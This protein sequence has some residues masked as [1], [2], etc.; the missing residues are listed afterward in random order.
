MIGD[1][2]HLHIGHQI[3]LEDQAAYLSREHGTSLV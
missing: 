1:V 3:R 2:V